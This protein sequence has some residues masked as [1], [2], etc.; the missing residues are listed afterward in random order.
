MTSSEKATGFLIF[1]SGGGHHESIQ[2]ILFRTGCRNTRT[3]I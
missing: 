1:F 2:R 3:T